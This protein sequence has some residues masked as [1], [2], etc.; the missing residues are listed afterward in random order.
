[1]SGSE[2]P[3]LAEMQQAGCAP[4]KLDTRQERRAERRGQMRVWK[5]S[6]KGKRR[7]LAGG[8]KFD[9][10]HSTARPKYEAASWP[11]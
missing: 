1:M 11:A 4:E 3:V 5:E 6:S 10:Q 9:S 8:P 7:D 2:D